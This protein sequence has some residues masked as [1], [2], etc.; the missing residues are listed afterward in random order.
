MPVAKAFR[1]K[2]SS[3]FL[4][5]FSRTQYLATVNSVDDVGSVLLHDLVKSLVGLLQVLAV[6]LDRIRVSTS[7]MLPT[8]ATLLSHWKL[9][10]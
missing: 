6:R 9:L 4:G 5:I 2:A 3:G 7:F 10:T 8:T 1:R